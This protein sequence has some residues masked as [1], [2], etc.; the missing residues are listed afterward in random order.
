MFYVMSSKFY[1]ILVG[2]KCE[3]T[4]P[5]VWLKVGL[6]RLY[7]CSSSEILYRVLTPRSDPT[8]RCLVTS[9]V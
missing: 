8:V 9:I 2:E 5:S 7:L 3:V 1:S 4:N 6:M